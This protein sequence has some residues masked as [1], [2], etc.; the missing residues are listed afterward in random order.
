LYYT[1]LQYDGTGTAEFRILVAKRN[2]DLEPFGKGA[3]IQAIS[4]YGI[5]GPSTALDDG[6]KTLYYHKQSTVDGS[7]HIYKVTRP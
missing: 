1:A 6:E 5:E 4:G 7:F 2:T 3:V